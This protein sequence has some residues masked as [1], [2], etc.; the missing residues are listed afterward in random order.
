MKPLLAHAQMALADPRDGLVAAAQREGQLTVIGLPRDW[1]GYGALIDAFKARYGLMVNELTPC[2]GSACELEAIKRNEPALQAP[3]VVDVG[4]SFGPAAKK[5]GLLQP[6]KI[7][8]WGSIP[9]RV[10]DPGGFWYGDYYG[11][12]AFEINA[13]RV[14]NVPLDWPDLLASEYKNSVA[15]AGNPLFSDQAIQAVYAAG[16]SAG[17]GSRDRAAGE[18]LR[19]FAELHRKGNLV[20]MVGDSDSLAQGVTPILIRWDYL[21]LGDR[22][23][24]AGNPKIEIVVPKTGIVGGVYVQ[25]ISA[26]APHPNAAKLWM[27]HLYSDEGQLTWLN[28]YCH[29]I[30]FE[31][32]VRRRKVPVKLLERLPEIK[33]GQAPDEPVFPTVE[34]QEKAKEIIKNGWDDIVG[35]TIPCPS[36]PPPT[37]SPTSLNDMPHEAPVHS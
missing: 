2:A 9:D 30:R 14:K 27:E 15:L 26:S 5:D 24:F 18:G 11:V 4:L 29:P 32:L 6:Y 21:A 10:K 31:D 23:R 13:D 12:L 22:D 34:E 19:F 16:L 28:G 35:V 8:T 25:A 7:S 36:P 37:L 1:C 3:D 17:D 33:N 20:P